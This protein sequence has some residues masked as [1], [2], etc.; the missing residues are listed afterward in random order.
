M[1]KKKTKQ[2]K[3]PGWLQK[4]A[5]G[6]LKGLKGFPYL[7]YLGLTMAGIINAFGVT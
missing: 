5:A 7:T 6:I 2:K 4:A 1:T 3:A